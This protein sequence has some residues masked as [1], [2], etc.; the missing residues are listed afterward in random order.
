[1]AAGVVG[2]AAPARDPDAGR[3]MKAVPRSRPRLLP[4]LLAL[5]AVLGILGVFGA[6]AGLGHWQVD[7][8]RYFHDHWAL[9]LRA[10]FYRFETSPRPI[11][12]LLIHLY[13]ALVLEL[14]RPL[15]EGAL[16][17]VWLGSL[18]GTVA[19]AHA[20]LRPGAGR[21]WA[22]LVLGV[23]PFVFTLVV[24]PVTEMFFWPVATAAYVPTA[25]AITALVFLLGEPPGERRQAWCGVALWVAALSHEI[26]AAFA[27]GFA[28]AAAVWTWQRRKPVLWWASPAWAG[29]AVM[30]SL[31]VFRSHFDA[32]GAEAKPYTGRLL[33]SFGAALRQMALDAVT[34]EPFGSGVPALVQKAAFAA[35]VAGVWS[36][37]GTARPNPWLA[38]CGAGLAVAVFFS[39]LAGFYHYGELCCERHAAI[40]QWLLAL[41]AVL[42][43]VWALAKQAWW[44]R[45][46]DWTG[47]LLLLASLGPLLLL[48]P[49]IREDF[50][51]L[52]LARSAR[53]RSWTSG[54]ATGVRMQFY[55]P[56]DSPTMLV[57]G[58]S[59]PVG[60]YETSTL[61]WNDLLH[62]VGRFFGKLG[63]DACLPW[64]TEQSFLIDG[65][66][67]VPACPPHDGPPDVRFNSDGS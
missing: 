58:T 44:Q 16:L 54:L 40:R 27:I 42:L 47:P 9:G 14:K 5:A 62:S 67:F 33:L 55:M 28:G 37:W 32:L 30:L 31:V 4:L 29:M 60:T 49:A 61:D 19:A 63:I 57:H 50:G 2:G 66:R 38:A 23:A 8:F 59:L 56:P 15:L 21:W 41:G 64:Q 43:A 6:Q 34:S 3:V 10:F 18:A 48:L 26:G 51:V 7:E 52:E 17:F 35:G 11:S 65:T 45:C 25:A 39:L 24:A 36:R 46:A 12:E 20:A 1:M 22:A 13:G 53:E